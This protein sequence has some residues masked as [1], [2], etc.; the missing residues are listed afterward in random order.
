MYYAKYTNVVQYT[1]TNSLV[2]TKLSYNQGK[3]GQNISDARH[4]VVKKASKSK[5][6]T[7]VDTP[8]E[9]SKHWIYRKWT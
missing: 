2:S 6:P 3:L 7:T 5:H 4:I 8:C 1:K 9:T